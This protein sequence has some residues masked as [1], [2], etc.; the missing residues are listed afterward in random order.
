MAPYVGS[1]T[2]EFRFHMD[3]D[4]LHNVRRHAKA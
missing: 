1:D 2:R 4:I 3:V